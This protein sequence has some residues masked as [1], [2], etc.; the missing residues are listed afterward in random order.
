[1]QQKI[2][3]KAA[4]GKSRH[5]IELYLFY[6]NFADAF[7]QFFGDRL[8][9][10]FLYPSYQEGLIFSLFAILLL[11]LLESLTPLPSPPSPPSTMKTVSKQATTDIRLLLE[12]GLKLRQT[13][14]RTGVGR[15]TVFKVRKSTEKVPVAS[16]GGRPRV[17]AERLTRMVV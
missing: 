12:N 14:V 9:F 8:R 15:F 6:F 13:A 4:V 5:W 10:F 2:A 17:M 3:C 16:K 1:M 11:P 7:G